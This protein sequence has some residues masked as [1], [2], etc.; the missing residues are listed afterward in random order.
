MR[1]GLVRTVVACVAALCVLG[2]AAPADAPGATTA[3]VGTVTTH[4]HTYLADARGRA[5]Q[6][7]GLNL[8]KTETVTESAVA[9]LAASGFDL[10]RLD[11][12][13]SRVEPRRG[14]Y[15]TAYLR[16]LD[17]VLSWADRYHVL[18]LADW[19]QDVYGPRFGGDGL[20]RWATRTDGLPFHHDP[21]DWFADYFQPAVQAAFRHL[22]DDQDLRAAQSAAYRTVAE[23]LRGHRSLLGYDLFNE[24]S[25]PFRGDPTDPTVQLAASAALERGRLAAMYRRAIA[26]IRTV[27]QR[28]WLFVEPTVL[29]G[30]GVPT[31][32]PGFTDPRG[33]PSRLGYAPHYYDTA[34]E[35]GADWNPGDGFI[36]RYESAI[37]RYPAAH[38][39]PVLVGEWGPPSATTVGNARLVAQQVASMRRFATGWT[40][41]YDCRAAHGVGYCAYDSDGRPAPGKHPAFWPYAAAVAGTP[42]TESYDPA[43]RTYRLTATLR[44]TTGRPETDIV[45]PPVAFPHGVC[46]TVSTRSVVL[47]EQPTRQHPGLA[48]VLPLHA[49][50]GERVTTDV[51]DQTD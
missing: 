48:R 10:V 31:R 51:S 49:R 32:L 27:D 30:E 7:H 22:Y 41:W 42:D 29:V 45:L 5:L 14:R 19:H 1:L 33:G 44:R 23:A 26:A 25:G 11:I 4:G 12:Q 13:W 9:G 8:G 16:Y 46:V 35:S 39:L 15:D 34:V 47:I 2:A 3:P 43:H 50:P 38:H 21:A 24:P 6:L 20:P 36:T 28:A 18:V 37:T 17:H 40:M